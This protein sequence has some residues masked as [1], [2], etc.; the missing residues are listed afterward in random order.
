MRHSAE[1]C[2]FTIKLDGFADERGAADY[3]QALSERRV[4]FI[5]DQFV[6]AAEM[7]ERAGFDMIELHA[8]HGYLI[9]SFISPVSNQRGDEYGGSLENRLRYPLEVFRAMRAVWPEDNFGDD[10]WCLTVDGV[11]GRSNEPWHPTL[12][13]AKENFAFKF[14]SAGFNCELGRIRL[15]R[16]ISSVTASGS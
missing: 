12:S 5:R 13:K 7:A 10:I 15:T 9:S 11:Q 2:P 6:A 8:A 1:V 3:N 4:Q 16:S 14:N